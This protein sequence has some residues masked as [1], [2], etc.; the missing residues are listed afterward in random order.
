[1]RGIVQGPGSTLRWPMVNMYEIRA[2]AECRGRIF[3]APFA[4]FR[5]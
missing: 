5:V 1:M 3:F 2:F 4:D